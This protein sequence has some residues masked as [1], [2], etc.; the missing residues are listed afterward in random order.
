MATFDIQNPGDWFYDTSYACVC[1]K[2]S[3]HYLG[4]KRS[5][6]CWNCASEKTKLWWVNLN[7]DKVPEELLTP[8]LKIDV[9]IGK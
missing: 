7:Q 2:C 1:H 9:R 8:T 6:F 4:P 3:D 5:G